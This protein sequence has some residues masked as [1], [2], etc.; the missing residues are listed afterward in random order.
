MIV[1]VNVRESTFTEIHILVGQGETWRESSVKGDTHLYEFD[2]ILGDLS[3]I[4]TRGALH[5]EDFAVVGNVSV[6]SL[7]GCQRQ[8]HVSSHHAHLFMGDGTWIGKSF[9]NV[10][11][12]CN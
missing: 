7:G 3:A 1:A 11:L 5:S 12:I 4:T 8:T 9:P 10:R 6:L 2:L